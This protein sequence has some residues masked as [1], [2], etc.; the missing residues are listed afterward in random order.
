MTPLAAPPESTLAPVDRGSESRTVDVDVRDLATRGRTVTGYAAVYNIESRDLGGFRERILPGAFADVL[1]ADADVRCL[2]NHDPNIVLGRTRAGTLRLSD[3]QRGLRFEVDLPESR[4]DLREA[5]ERGDLDGASFRFEV[6][7]DTWAGEVRSIDRIRALHDVSI[8]THPAYPAASIELRTANPPASSSRPAPLELGGV[9]VRDRPHRAA[10]IAVR[11]RT[12][13]DEFRSAGFP[14]LPGERSIIPWERMDPAPGMR[15][16]GRAASEQRALTWSGDDTLLNSYARQIPPLAF[17]ER[18]AFTALRRMAVE[19]S[20]TSVSLLTQT[21]RSLATAANVVRALNAVTAKPETGSTVNL[22]QADLKQVATIQTAIP[23]I[24]LTQPGFDSIIE[25]DLRLAIYS[26]L[27]KLV[28]D[29]TAASGFQAPSTDLLIVSVRKAITTLRAAGFS[30]D[31]LILTPAASEALDTLVSGITGATADWAN[32]PG[33]FTAMRRV[34]S[35]TAAAPI[36]MDSAAFGT[37]YVSPVAIA[38]F[39][40]DDGTTNTSNVRMETTA[41]FGV[42]RQ[43]AAVRVA[44]S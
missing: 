1:N 16:A 29:G 41:V 24:Y 14:G 33:W 17:D 5:V 28:L 20:T 15:I 35:K 7:H 37:L 43:T 9:I 12:L 4:S 21:N 3:E 10:G 38:R 36:V 40:A 44:A 25:N 19:G 22:T 23:N 34:E 39:E 42:E 11:G 30:A 6:A 2:L 18:Y 31:L 13:A 8:A 32:L 26:G 27:D